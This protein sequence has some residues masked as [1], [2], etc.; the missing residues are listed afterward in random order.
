MEMHILHFKG[1]YLSRRFVFIFVNSVDPGE[2]SQHGRQISLLHNRSAEY[3]MRG[4]ELRLSGNH[5]VTEYE[6]SGDL[7]SQ[8]SGWI[9][10]SNERTFQVM[11]LK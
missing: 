1:F 9:K 2:I 3:I 10:H 11:T 8:K 6:M 7:Y 4:G 5:T